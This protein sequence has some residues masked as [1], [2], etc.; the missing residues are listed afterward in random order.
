MKPGDLWTE[1]CSHSPSAS[2]EIS[3]MKWEGA[4]DRHPTG[5]AQKTGRTGRWEEQR[6]WEPGEE[7]EQGAWRGDVETETLRVADGSLPFRTQKKGSLPEQFGP[8]SLKVFIHHTEMRQYLLLCRYHSSTKATPI[9]SSN[10]RK[11]ESQV[12]KETEEGKTSMHWCLSHSF[13]QPCTQQYIGMRKRPRTSI[14]VKS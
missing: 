13:P 4:E 5:Q 8:V 1:L 2:A 6:G 3:D 14:M 11:A 12:G 7:D 10:S 9:L